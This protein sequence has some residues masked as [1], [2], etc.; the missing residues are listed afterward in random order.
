MAQAH[1]DLI[2]RSISDADAEIMWQIVYHASHVEEDPGATRLSMRTN[3]DLVGHVTGWGRAGDLGIVAEQ[4]GTVVGAAWLRL[5]VGEE[6]KLSYFVDDVTPELVIAVLPGNQG[7]GVGTSI[8]TELLNRAAS[9]YPRIMLTVRASS[10]AVRLYERF[11]FREIQRLT[12][13]VGSISL[14]MRLV[15][16]T[17]ATSQNR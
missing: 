11:G 5:L 15:L 14:E 3:P 4:A 12:N 9:R 16:D 17:A 13:R 10:P 6:R 8:L 1:G 2:Y 7:D